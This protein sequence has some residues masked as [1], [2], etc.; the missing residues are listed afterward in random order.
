MWIWHGKVWLN[1]FQCANNN[2]RKCP[3]VTSAQN[4]IENS[5]LV[6]SLDHWKMFTSTCVKYAYRLHFVCISLSVHDFFFHFLLWKLC[7]VHR[8]PNVT[9]LDSLEWQANTWHCKYAAVSLLFLFSLFPRLL[10]YFTHEFYASIKRKR[11]DAHATCMQTVKIGT[12][13]PGEGY[14]WWASW[15]LSISA[16]EDNTGN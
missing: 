2:K 4:R 8:P 1:I 11:K 7:F 10:F 9:V 12:P 5:M 15:I 6:M 3:N 13:Y 16:D 14:P